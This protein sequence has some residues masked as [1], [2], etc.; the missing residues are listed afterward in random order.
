MTLDINRNFSLWNVTLT[1][2]NPTI[3][4]IGVQKNDSKK[5]ETKIIKSMS[6]RKIRFYIELIWLSYQWEQPRMII[7]EENFDFFK[8]KLFRKTIST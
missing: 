6:L 8:K 7:N 1:E 2:T 5:N 4:S 3:V